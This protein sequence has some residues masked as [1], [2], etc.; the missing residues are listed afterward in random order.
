[1]YVATGMAEEEYR[2]RMVEIHTAELK[3]RK[4]EAFWSGVI[5]L[6][7]VAV[8]LATFFGVQRWLAASKR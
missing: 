7:T 3:H 2:Q 4:H 1:M 6:A 8:P 5:A